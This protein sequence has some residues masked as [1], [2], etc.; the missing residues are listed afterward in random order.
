MKLIV[1]LGN[2][3]TQ[4]ANTRHNV[5]WMAIDE[6]AKSCEVEFTQKKFNAEL[7]SFTTRNEKIILMK[8]LTYMNLSG[9][10][11]LAC[12]NYYK[13]DTKDILIIHDDMDLPVGTT[14]IRSKGSSG[15]QKGMQ[16]IIELL[17]TQDIA[18][19]RI[20]IGKDKLIPVVDYVLGKVREEDK[21]VF[22]KSIET[23][24]KAAKMFF[25][26]EIELVMSRYNKRDKKVN[27]DN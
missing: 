19:I 14:R 8:P 3:G 7:A 22:D 6:L 9:E 26:S 15:G 13:I 12:V 23:A 16:N 20:G 5:G 27:T 11:V 21:E 1:G 18:R 4:Y 24:V 25:K 10:A 17:H 2:P